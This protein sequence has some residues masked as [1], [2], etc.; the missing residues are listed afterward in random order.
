MRL[1]CSP[2]ET[3]PFSGGLPVTAEAKRAATR[4]VFRVSGFGFGKVKCRDLQRG[5]RGASCQGQGV[6]S[7]QHTIRNKGIEDG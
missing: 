5:P 3:S 4:V 7:A 1:P 2:A 6:T